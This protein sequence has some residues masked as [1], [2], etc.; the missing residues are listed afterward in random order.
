L[1]EENEKKETNKELSFKR[2]ANNNNN[3]NT[4]SKTNVCAAGV[5]KN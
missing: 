5:R 1:S 4:G 2:K 3:N